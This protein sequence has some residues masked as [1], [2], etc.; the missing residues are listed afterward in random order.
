M[1]N[2]LGVPVGFVTAGPLVVALEKQFVG[3]DALR[4]GG[5]QGAEFAVGIDQA[6]LF[7]GAGVVKT[8]VVFPD[9]FAGP[10]LP[11]LFPVIAGEVAVHG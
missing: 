8:A 3:H 7:G 4:G 9:L 5:I 10:P 6:F 11:N 2:A 1:G